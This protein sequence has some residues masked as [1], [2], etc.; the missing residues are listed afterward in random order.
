MKVDTCSETFFPRRLVHAC[1]SRDA[2]PR[3]ST[4]GQPAR[5]RGALGGGLSPCELDSPKEKW[6]QGGRFPQPGRGGWMVGYRGK[7]GRRQGHGLWKDREPGSGE[8]PRHWGGSGGGAGG[9]T[10][11]GFGGG[12]ATFRALPRWADRG[13]ASR[14]RRRGLTKKETRSCDCLLWE[15]EKQPYV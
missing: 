6:G 14:E 2:R 10:C 13:Q 3:G 5:R 9:A 15:R 7:P 11:W 4:G 12:A 8:W 1:R